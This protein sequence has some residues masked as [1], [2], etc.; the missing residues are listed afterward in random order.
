MIQKLCDL[1]GLPVA[2]TQCETCLGKI[3]YFIYRDVALTQKRRVPRVHGGRC[4]DLYELKKAR[5]LVEKYNRKQE[6]KANGN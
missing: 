5:K 1:T 6:R 2:D 4:R 3:T